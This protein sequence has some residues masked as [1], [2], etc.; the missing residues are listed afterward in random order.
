MSYLVY[1]VAICIFTLLDQ[2][3]KKQIVNYLKLGEKIEIIKGFFNITHV[4][5]YGAGFSILQN[6]R[7][8]LSLVSIIAIVVLVY[9]LVTTKKK[10]TL[11]SMS[12]LMVISGALG[13]LLDR[14][15]QGYV[16]D[17]LDFTIFGWDYPVFNVADIF[18]TIGC[19]LLIII[20]LKGE[21]DA[22]N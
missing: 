20:S 4:R 11:T 6:A 13:N 9:L 5:N 3:S 14:L 15:R 10:N 18:I 17:F 8:F 12:Y 7:L 22:K 1:L 2:L 21:K 19:F 16:V